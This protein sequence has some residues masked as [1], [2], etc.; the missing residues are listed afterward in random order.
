[1]SRMSDLPRKLRNDAILEALLEL[2]FDTSDVPE[3]AVGRLI[4]HPQWRAFAQNR[5]PISNIPADFR[6]PHHNLR[7]QPTVELRDRF[8]TQIL[9][10]GSNVLSL[11][12]LKTYKGWHTDFQ[13]DLVDM[14]R[15][16]SDRVN[17]PRVRRIGL[18]YLNALT[19]NE[20]DIPSVSDLHI[21]LSATNATVN[22]HLN[23]NYRQIR[24]RF[25][26]GTRVST[27]DF[28]QGSAPADLSPF[29]DIDVYTP[30]DIDCSSPDGAID[31][32]NEVYDLEK[33]AFFGLIPESIP[34]ELVEE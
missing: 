29:V 28:V 4:D 27:P 7:Y 5:T 25:H 23:I 12:N 11:H 9:R 15:H 10:A 14:V 33:G 1:M 13:E 18:R 17:S 34:A 24:E 8:G 3:V 31:W 21:S 6:L 2:R 16:L 22:D 30:N 19:S 20:H 26:I 32:I